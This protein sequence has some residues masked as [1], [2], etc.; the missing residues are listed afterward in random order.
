M[1][2]KNILLYC[3]LLFQF[4]VFS[5]KVVFNQKI[6]SGSVLDQDSRPLV[7]ATVYIN[8]SSSWDITNDEG[9]FEISIKKGFYNLI[10]SYMGYET[11]RYTIRSE[12]FDRDLVFQM[13]PALNKLDEIVVKGNKKMPKRKRSRYMYQFIQNFI[14]TSELADKCVILNE[15]IINLQYDEATETLKAYAYEPL[16]IKHYGLGYM[17]TYDLEYFQKSPEGVSYLGYSRYEEIESSNRNKKN[18][19][20]TEE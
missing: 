15:D 16:K 20:G 9:K 7:G 19:A 1:R 5:Q 13:K 6:L 2:T 18:G 17:I 8:N 3:L 10:I 11:I 14:G 12:D 4:H